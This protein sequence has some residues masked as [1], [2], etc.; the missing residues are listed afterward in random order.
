M[1][2]VGVV[3][4]ILLWVPPP[5][6]AL[7]RGGHSYKISPKPCSVNGVEGTCMFVWECIK[8]E[9]T[10]VGMCVDTFMFG[11][12]CSHNTS[13]NVV[14]SGSSEPDILF[15]PPSHTTSPTFTA[16]PPVPTMQ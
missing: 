13:H 3:G 12:C 16:R 5:G 2:W 10:H 4:A 15:S 6:A 7:Q 8:T 11:S 14:S 1:L 9:G